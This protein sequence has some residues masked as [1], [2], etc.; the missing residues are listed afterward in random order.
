MAAMK[1]FPMLIPCAGPASGTL[2]VLAPFDSAVIA[3]L[4]VNPWACQ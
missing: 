4:P 2:E 1:E 3:S